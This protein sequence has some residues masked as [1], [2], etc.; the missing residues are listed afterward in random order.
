MTTAPGS[1]GGL[2]RPAILH[3]SVRDRQ[4][5]YSA[6]MP[7]IRRGAIFVPTGRLL[8]LGDP[9]YLLLTLPDDGDRLPVAGSVAWLTPAAA[10]G[11]KPQGAGVQFAD[12]EIGVAARRRIEAVLTGMLDSPKSTLTL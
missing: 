8:S 10:S 2:G 12:D 7:Q 3:V 5:L 6:Y 9:V 4:A 1:I 11:G